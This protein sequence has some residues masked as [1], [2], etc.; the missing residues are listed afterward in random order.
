MK[1]IT[2]KMLRMR[3]GGAFVILV[4]LVVALLIAAGVAVYN[5]SQQ[6]KKQAGILAQGYQLFN[7]G[8]FSEAYDQFQSAKHTFTTTLNLYRQLK[9]SDAYVTLV[10]INEVVVSICLSAAYDDFFELN[11]S[12]EW[13]VKA[14]SNLK[15]HEPGPR[16]EELN[17][18]LATARTV[19][20]LCQTFKAGD[21]EKAMKGLLESEKN[22]LPTD[23]DFFIFEIRMLIACGKALDDVDVINQAR[24]LLFFATTDA[25]INNDKTGKLWVLLTN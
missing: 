19:S 1:K 13:L 9:K 14:E 15:Q 6:Q 18:T 17:Q 12:E 11:S 10:D 4:L 25:G 21:V 16:K 2:N 22:A 5:G 24:E 7:E 20:K 8:K 3:T 23:Q